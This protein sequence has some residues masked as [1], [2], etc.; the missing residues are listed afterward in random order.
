ME[1]A[2]EVAQVGEH[3]GDL[4][5]RI[6]VDAVQADEG[7]EHEQ[8]GLQ[9]RDRLAQAL[10][11]LREIQAHGRSRD[12][13]DVER[14]ERHPGGLRN[15]HQARPHD[16]ERIFRGE[17]QDAPGPGGAKPPQT[18]RA[19]GDRD[20]HVEGQKRLAAL[21]LA[22][23]DADRL[24]GPEVFD[25]PALLWGLDIGGLGGPHGQRGHR[26][27]SAGSRRVLAGAADRGGAKT[28]R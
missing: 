4:G 22:A 27:A 8:R 5:R 19:G 13:L 15:A 17:E 14:V 25:Q 12:D 11:V 23:D 26:W 21:G 20:G 9:E 1:V 7:I 3:G 28:S 24:S 10:L 6:F 18:R 16:V 2:L